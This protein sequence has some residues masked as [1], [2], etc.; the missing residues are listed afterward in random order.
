MCGIF[1]YVSRKEKANIW[2]VL[3]KGLH[4]LEYRG[5]DSAGIAIFDSKTDEVET[6]LVILNGPLRKSL[7]LKLVLPTFQKIIV[8]L[9]FILELLTT[10]WRL[11]L[12]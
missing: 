11:K 10:R 8:L 4:Q 12:S 6:D 3:E 5:Y 9:V 1:G 7:R 2:N